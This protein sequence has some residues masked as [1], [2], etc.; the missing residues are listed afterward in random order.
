MRS[1]IVALMAVCVFSTGCNKEDRLIDKVTFKPSDNLETIRVSL[2]FTKKVQADWAGG[3][4]LKHYGYIFVNPYTEAQPFEVGFDLNTAIVNEQDYVNI[5]PTTVF[6]N[7]VPLGI[8][9]ALVQVQAETPIHPKFDLYAYVDVL[10]QQWLGLASIFS[11]LSDR[12][13]P[14]GLSISQIFW[15]DP[16]GNP[17][18]IGAAFGP[19][20]RPDGSLERAGGI[21]VLANVRA[22]LASG[23]LQPGR[24]VTFEAL[25]SIELKGPA[26]PQYQ[27][28]TKALLKIE[29]NLIN[30]LNEQL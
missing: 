5:T 3:F 8:D 2:Q 16:A 6:P 7:G 12:Y 18:I 22:L 14:A 11:F 19:K 17:G 23:K 27:G 21:A 4:A 10:K 26:A 20:V 25:G 24:A 15:R 29:Q 13:F 28:N 30:G 1:L 9:H